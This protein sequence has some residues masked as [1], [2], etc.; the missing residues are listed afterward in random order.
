[1]SHKWDGDM[2]EWVSMGIVGGDVDEARELVDQAIKHSE[3]FDVVVI[4]V[5]MNDVK[6]WALP[7]TRNRSINRY[8]SSTFQYQL[9]RIIST[10][11]ATCGKH[12]QIVLPALPI[13]LSPVLS[14]QPLAFFLRPAFTCWDQKKALLA[15]QCSGVQFVA[16]PDTLQVH[17]LLTRLGLKLN[18][19]SASDDHTRSQVTSSDRVHPND[20]GYELWGC[21]IADS[22]PVSA[23]ADEGCSNIQQADNR[24]RPTGTPRPRSSLALK[25]PKANRRCATGLSDSKSH[26]RRE[27]IQN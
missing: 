16:P 1:M 18:L 27:M 10:I 22:I 9:L 23:Q 21:H 6:R 15:E 11:R 25:A 26:K 14:C 4:I 5:G 24:S 2:V 13:S 19:S 20:I 7:W 17:S 3:Y 8:S 12:T